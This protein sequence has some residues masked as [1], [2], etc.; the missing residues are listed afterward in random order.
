MVLEGVLVRLMQERCGSLPPS[1][2]RMSACALLC[3][4]FCCGEIG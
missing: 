2:P 4:A 1:A 3:P